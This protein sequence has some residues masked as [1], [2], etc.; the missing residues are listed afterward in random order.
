M[1]DP[2]TRAFSFY[3]FIVAFAYS[4][5]NSFVDAFSASIGLAGWA[6]VLFLAYAIAL[7]LVRPPLGRLQDR[8]GENAVLY[9]S[10]ACMAVGTLLCTACSA[11]PSPALLVLVGVFAALGFG[12]CMSSGLAV[13]GRLSGGSKA[14]PGIA[15]F[16]LLCDFGC[17]IGPFLLG[18]IVGSFGY[19]TMYLTCAVVSLAGLVY[20]HVSHGRKQGAVNEAE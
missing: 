10:I 13:V 19:P 15:T 16:Y 6:A 14:A 4:S 5:I 20:Y 7:V 1:F 8:K 2:A 18:A 12:T 17:G 9:P 3:M 11:L